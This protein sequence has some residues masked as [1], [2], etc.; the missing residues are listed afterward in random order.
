MFRTRWDKCNRFLVGPVQGIFSLATEI[1]LI[2]R[3]PCTVA[4]C[5]ATAFSRGELLGLQ[6]KHI[7]FDA[8]TIQIEQGLW[9]GQ[10]FSDNSRLFPF[11]EALALGSIQ[12]LSEHAPQGADDFVFCK[13]D[14]FALSIDI[15]ASGVSSWPSAGGSEGKHQ[16]DMP[17]LR[18]FQITLLHLEKALGKE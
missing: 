18:R 8:P 4:R 17:L 11:G 3:S 7:D 15:R 12:P 2:A 10:L 6:W 5:C 14:E 13:K 1:D 9:H 16:S